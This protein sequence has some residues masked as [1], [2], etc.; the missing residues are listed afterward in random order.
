MILNIPELGGDP[1]EWNEVMGVFRNAEGNVMVRS[2]M[3]MLIGK[4]AGARL[5]KEMN[6]GLPAEECK[7]AD[8]EARCA[9][10]VL[11]WIRK[12]VRGEGAKVDAGVRKLFG[13]SVAEGGADV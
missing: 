4:M 2:V 12:L 9:N 6:P 3:L 11:G 5:D 13:E 7:F 1:P 10:D 8:G